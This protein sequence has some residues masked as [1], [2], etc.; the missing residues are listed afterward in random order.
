MS[1]ENLLKSLETKTQS[2]E[3]TIL[4]SAK[5][6]AKRVK[7]D[8]S[9]EAKRIIDQ[10]KAEGQKIGAEQQLEIKANTKLKQKRIVSQTQEELMRKSIDGLKDLLEDFASTKGYDDVLTQ[11]ATEC[12][13]S[14]GEGTT[15]YCRKEDE[16]KLKAADFKIAGII[17]TIGGVIGESKDGRIKVNNSFESLLDIHKEKLKQ[18]A[19]GE[20]VDA[21]VIKPSTSVSQVQQTKE[22]VQKP[23]A[24]KIAP[25][26]PIQK[27]KPVA[28]KQTKKKR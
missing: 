16:K 3:D 18:A 1:F 20:L 6:E 12:T 11:L 10:A 4:S 21:I 27:Q 9:S 7:S 28:V 15:L 2:D 14:L 24:T 22:K 17:K 19:F 8:A 26:K 5:N 25:T 23:L 13:T